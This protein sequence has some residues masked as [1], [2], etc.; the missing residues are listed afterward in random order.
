MLDNP[1]RKLTQEEVEAMGLKYYDSDVHKAAFVLPQF[2]K[3]VLLPK[4]NC[5]TEPGRLLLLPSLILQCLALDEPL[6]P[7][8]DEAQ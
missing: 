3:K 2:V 6:P 7:S 1:V 5:V 8:D 4:P